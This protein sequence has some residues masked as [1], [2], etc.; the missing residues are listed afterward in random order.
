MA[1]SAKDRERWAE[2]DLVIAEHKAQLKAATTHEA[3]K[4]FATE[5]GWMNKGDFGK[6]KTSLRKIGIK[7][8]QLRAETFAKQDKQRADELAA[9]DDD[10][11]T[12]RLWTAAVEVKNDASFAV[13]DAHNNAVWYGNFFDDD[14]IRVV[15]DVIS[16]EQS[17]ADK[18][19]WIAGKALEATGNTV[20]RLTIVTTC[21]D[22][23]TA[24]LVATGA[25]FGL[26][27]TVELDDS[28]VRAVEMAE[29]PGYQS[30]QEADLTELVED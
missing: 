29:A 2:I 18:A 15:G 11:P 3:L 24:Q 16:A 23:D 14:R 8:D 7:Y 26:A 5:Q 6:F 28:D 4:N 13:V 25:R 19:V 22:L 10:A 20:A 12:I 9:L 21:P 17:V 27:V 30:W 1:L